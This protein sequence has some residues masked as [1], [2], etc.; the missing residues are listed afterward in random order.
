VYT[1]KVEPGPIRSLM[2]PAKIPDSAKKLDFWIR[3]TAQT[4]VGLAVG[5][6]DGSSYRLSIHVPPHEWT[7]VSANLS[8][9]PLDENGTD[10]NGKLDPDQVNHIGLLDLGTFLVNAPGGALAVQQGQRQLWLDGLRFSP[11]TSVQAAGVVKAGTTSS[12]LIDNFEADGTR[13]MPARITF[14]PQLAFEIFPAETSLKIMTEAAAPGD[15]KT[16]TDPGGKGLRYSYKRGAMEV[17]ALTRNIQSPEMAKAT[18]LR[19][20]VRASQ[21]SL[22]V[23]MVK[24]KDDSEYN[25]TIMPDQS[26][27]WQSLDVAL[28]ELAL[29]NDS[30]DEN[31]QLDPGQIKD[32]TILDG[33]ALLGPALNQGDT[34]L[35]LD[36]I[37]FALK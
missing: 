20:S 29:G 7:H 13:W 10:E 4:V 18:R 1:Y 11:E 33:S 3:G 17:F 2:A 24:E 23:I 35:E 34:T 19:I 26:E 14:G 22:L 37:S 36:A 27:G 15:A 28:S 25:H 5:E 9:I 16:P 12:L 6:A 21:K 32:I 31:N 30:K 8:E